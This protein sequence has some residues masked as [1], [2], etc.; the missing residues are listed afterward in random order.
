VG[1]VGQHPAPLYEAYRAS[2]TYV[3]ADA[4]VVLLDAG[5]PPGSDLAR[6]I[7][8]AIVAIGM[9]LAQVMRSL[10]AFPVPDRLGRTPGLQT[11]MTSVIP[12]RPRSVRRCGHGALASPRQRMSW[13]HR[14]WPRTRRRVHRRSRFSGGIDLASRAAGVHHSVSVRMLWAA[15]AVVSHLQAGSHLF[16]RYSS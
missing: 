4:Q 5:R 6:V 8:L 3:S 16:S 9:L 7:P 12:G 11:M 1:P 2:T 15:L 13:C 14:C 10:V